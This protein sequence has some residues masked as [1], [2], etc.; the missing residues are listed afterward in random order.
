MLIGMIT[1]MWKG[2]V[3][4][5]TIKWVCTLGVTRFKSFFF[6]NAARSHVLLVLGSCTILPLMRGLL[7]PPWCVFCSTFSSNSFEV[8]ASSR[9]MVKMTWDPVAAKGSPILNVPIYTPL[10]K[11]T[12]FA[13]FCWHS[14]KS[15]ILFSGLDPGPLDPLGHRKCFK[16]FF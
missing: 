8:A 13:C 12:V 1:A 2:F 10:R 11:E 9:S 3:H 16:D 15:L 5:L 6:L 7:N 4:H 14:N